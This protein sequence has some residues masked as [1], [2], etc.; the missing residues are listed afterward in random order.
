MWE[1]IEISANFESFCNYFST[2]E[3]IFLEPVPAFLILNDE[4][5]TFALSIPGTI[6]LRY[7]QL[8]IFGRGRCLTCNSVKAPRV[9]HEEVS[10]LL[11]MTFKIV[12]NVYERS[13]ELWYWPNFSGSLPGP[14]IPLSNKK[15]AI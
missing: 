8:S 9:F 6:T 11:D 5:D 4:L 3:A 13:L 10:T 2:N 7:K 1:C 14:V 15:N 12:S